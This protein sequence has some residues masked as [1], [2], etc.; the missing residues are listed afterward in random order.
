[1]LLAP[2]YPVSYAYKATELVWV[3]TS[4]Y[5]LDDMPHARTSR[6][7]IHLQCVGWEAKDVLMQ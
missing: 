5:F 7:A 4:R 3:L 6:E 2:Y 1:M